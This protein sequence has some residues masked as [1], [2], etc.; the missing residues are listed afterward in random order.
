M[1]NLRSEDHILEIIDEFFPAG[2]DTFSVGRGD[3]CAVWQPG[4]PV[5]VSTDLFLENVHF[6]RRYF[7][8]E[9]I[10]WKALA[11]N[12]SDLAAMGAQPVGFSVGLALPPD[13][14]EALVRGICQGMADLLATAPECRNTCLCGGDISRA[15]KLHL[16]LTVF[17]ETDN[18]PP[19]LR[20]NC[21][22]GDMIF[23]IGRAGLARLG[24]QFMESEGRAAL[25]HAPEACAALLR[26]M[27][28]VREGLRL[29]ALAARDSARIGL[30]DISDG[31]ARDLPRLLG[32]QPRNATSKKTIPWGADIR[33][34]L[35]HEECRNHATAQG[36]NATRLTEFQYAGG[37]D[38][39][40]LGFCDPAISS[41]LMVTLPET[42]PL[43]RVTADGIFPF[44]GGFD[45]FE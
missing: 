37:D 20:G 45:H 12:L 44:V 1:P 27:P 14:D 10:G 22:L 42:A 13:A 18:D 36:W 7:T 8:P 5:C 32:K 30:M 33:L 25:E 9:D 15:D 35:A 43:G 2:A 4:G 26:P 6:R 38:Y 11:V 41:Q 17:G 23:L 16:C 21:R 29:R 19:L 28:R 31:I 3:D 39:A 34:P 24:L 40:L